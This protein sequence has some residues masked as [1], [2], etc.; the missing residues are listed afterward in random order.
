MLDL[1]LTNKVVIVTGAGRGIG[2]ATARL[3]AAQGAHV[4][5]AARTDSE[6]KEVANSING[7]PVVCDVRNPTDCE[8]LVAE[9]IKQFGRVDVLVNNAGAVHTAGPFTDVNDDIWEDMYAVNVLGAV[10]LSRLVAQHLITEGRSGSI[11]N[12]TSVAGMQSATAQIAYGA[13]KAALIS[14]TQTTAKEL[15]RYGIR[16]NAIACGLV[17]TRMADPVST[18]ATLHQKFLHKTPLQM[19]GEPE[20]IAH[21]IAFLA[22]DLSCFTT[23]HTMIVDGGISL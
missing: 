8:R 6:I 21:A 14:Q 11:V 1:S 4:A 5:L 16:V 19:N 23:G 3:F 9:T 22:S 15:G 20:D 17:R 12:V 13:S 18:N 7:Y 2:A 10:R